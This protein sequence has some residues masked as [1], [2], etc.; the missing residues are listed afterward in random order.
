[1]AVLTLKGSEI[2][3]FPPILQE[4]ATHLS[5]IKGNSEKTVC[6]YLLDLRT[7]FRYLKVKDGNIPERDD[8]EKISIK[9]VDLEF[10]RQIKIAIIKTGSVATANANITIT[11][12][13]DIFIFH[14]PVPKH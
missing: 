6:E 9:D 11:F 3:T 5:V 10:I 13:S 14:P 7:F 1:M 12:S 4:Y 8:F 2:K